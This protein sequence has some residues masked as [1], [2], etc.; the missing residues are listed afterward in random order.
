MNTVL[1]VI[2]KILII[3]IAA[4]IV[5]GLL[6]GVDRKL[7]AK[8]Q[9]RKGPPILQPFY[10]VIK[11]F[12]KETTTVNN[13]T[14]FYVAISLFF[15]IFTVVLFC[16]GMD[17]LLCVF[18]FTLACMFFVIAGYSSY[19]PFSF[20]GTERELI[21]IMCYEPMILIAAFG[22]YEAA[23]TFSIGGVFGLSSPVILKLPLIFIG[24]TYILT[25][26]LRKSPFDLSMS[27]H[28]HQEIVKGI[29][30]ELTGSSLAMVEIT[31]WYETIFSLG[32]VYIFFAYNTTASKI[33]AAV[34]CLV[35]Y[36]LEILIDNTFARVK[37]QSALKYSWIITLITGALNLLYFN[38]FH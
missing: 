4:P 9:R 31:H 28:G 22:Y 25:I 12:Q 32:F 10:D 27:H 36:F 8:M 11:L 17:L 1:F 30:T 14:R 15:T 23:G 18:S 16:L 24:L 33:I 20:I 3:V 34:I 29:T 21:Q 38:F 2:I 19:S 5:G 7:S 13:F 6:S 26:K 37:W 35:V